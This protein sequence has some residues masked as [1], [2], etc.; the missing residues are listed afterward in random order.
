MHK[1]HPAKTCVL[2]HE[3]S[4][5]LGKKEEEEEEEEESE[6]VLATRPQHVGKERRR[7][8]GGRRQ[9]SFFGLGWLGGGGECC[10]FPQETRHFYDALTS[11][12]RRP[13]LIFFASPFEPY[14]S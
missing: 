5:E 11:G 13:T 6:A 2:R 1:T 12:G 7:A 8:E 10:V 9:G 14:K 3:T 4:P